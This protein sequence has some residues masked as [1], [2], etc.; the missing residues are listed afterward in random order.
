MLRWTVFALS[1]MLAGTAVAGDQGRDERV[2]E[3]CTLLVPV[4]TSLLEYPKVRCEVRAIAEFDYACDAVG[5]DVT[6]EGTARGQG[7]YPGAG[8]VTTTFYH[9]DGIAT[10]ETS[11]CSGAGVTPTEC[12]SHHGASFGLAAGECAVLGIQARFWGGA[13]AYGS[14]WAGGEL[15]RSPD[16][17]ITFSPL[18]SASGSWRREGASDP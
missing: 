16:G 11:G 8:Y 6:M 12:T 9:E 18:P 10:F 13:A 1:I 2:S 15:C 7:E 3:A 5:C 17:A 14:A 4:G